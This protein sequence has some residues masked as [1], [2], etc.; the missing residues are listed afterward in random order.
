MRFDRRAL[1][2]AAAIVGWGGCGTSD[3]AGMNVADDGVP[4]QLTAFV[5]V[6]E[7]DADSGMRFA[8]AEWS[9]D[10]PVRAVVEY[11]STITELWRHT[12]SGS[13]AFAEAGRA[14]LVAVEPN[15]TY[16]YQV[17]MW[18]RG[19]NTR[20]Q[21][22]ES[23]PTFTPGSVDEVPLFLLAMIDVG[24]GDALYLEAPDGTNVLIDAGHPKDGP[25]VRQF[26]DDHDV[27]SLDFASL[28][29]VHEDHV[30]GFYGDTF[31]GFNGLFVIHTANGDQPIPV[32][33]F[34]DF[35]DK[36]AVNGPYGD[37]AEA[38][39]GHPSI[40][41]HVFLR[42]GASSASEPALRWGDGVRVDLLAA[43]RK[44]YLLPDF[45]YSAEPGSVENN[46]SM[47]YR[48]QYG[49]FVVLLTGDAEFAT[50]QFLQN[51]YPP[52]FLR[53]T[54]LKLGHHG[55]NDASSERFINVVSP[56][57]GLITNAISENPGVQHP[58]VLNRLLNRAIDYYASDRVEPNRARELSG[59]RGDVLVYSDGTDYSVIVENV[60]YE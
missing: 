13:D 34:L 33:T 14:R 32:G 57:V 6:E 31:I 60:R 17:R 27:E 10:E 43:G 59:V 52:P 25:R 49:D 5:V 48:V 56:R 42:Y 19:G 54:I 51:H 36:T 16:E 28:S 35:E 8:Y 7:T 18:D 23:A 24:W 21:F 50:E 12:Y 55:S 11:G 30:G 29:H 37:L 20:S 38:I 44:P 46:D 53:A 39:A 45:I 26:L 58:F 15:A 1:G 2:L 22:V 47:V 3:D 41:E 40:A 9:A 4:P